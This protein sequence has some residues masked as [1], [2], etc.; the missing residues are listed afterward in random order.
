MLARVHWR[1]PPSVACPNTTEVAAGGQR[2]MRHKLRHNFGDGAVI[3]R[4]APSYPAGGLSHR[5]CATRD[6]AVCHRGTAA[7]TSLTRDRAPRFLS[8]RTALAR[9]RL[10]WGHAGKVPAAD[11]HPGW[12]LQGSPELR[13][14]GMWPLWCAALAGMLAAR[15]K[16][17]CGRPRGWCL[18]AVCGC[19]TD[20]IVN[21]PR[22]RGSRAQ[23]R[24]LRPGS[25]CSHQ[26][27]R[28]SG[29]V[30][31]IGPGAGDRLATA[32]GSAY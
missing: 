27:A 5:S 16:L 14:P 3:W 18:G 24:L 10:R 29:T 12:P 23:R 17:V 2:R 11:H 19:F 22:D 9:C 7:W 15:C 26:R 6:G 4:T 30:P 13:E 28:S 20:P 25:A 31:A 21:G 32:P 8:G 1:P